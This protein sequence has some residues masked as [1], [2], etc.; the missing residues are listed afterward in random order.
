MIAIFGAPGAGK[1]MQG[2]L[3]SRKYGWGWYSSRD[4]LLGMNDRETTRALNYGMTV[5]D[6]KSIEAMQRVFRD[7]H[8]S[9][10]Q[11]VLDGFPSSVRQVYWMVESGEIRNL[12]GAIILRVPRGELWKRLVERK[13]VDDTRAAIERRQ[14][15][16]ERAITG[17]IRVLNQNGVPT[18]E[19]DG[20]NTP[21]DVL[22][23]VE[24]V[25]A[26]WNLVAEKQFQDIPQMRTITPQNEN[27]SAQRTFNMIAPQLE[28]RLRAVVANKGAS[29]SLTELFSKLLES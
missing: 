7:I 19:V 21:K 14:D 20:G 25:L 5:D 10:R 18:R 29:D 27:G 26:D 28:Q 9:G 16:Y 24:E 11:A 23:R 2:Q 1:S 4:L 15:Q 3:L 22:E 8:R 17:M 6:E 12:T 13:R